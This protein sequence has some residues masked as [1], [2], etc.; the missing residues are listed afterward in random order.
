MPFPWIMYNLVFYDEGGVPVASKGMICSIVILFAMLIFVIVSIAAF[1][2]KMNK[3]LG[4][5]MFVLY[6]AF[7]AVSLLFEMKVLVCRLNIG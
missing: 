1:K 3:G 4:I 2:W 7:V 5:T 6:L